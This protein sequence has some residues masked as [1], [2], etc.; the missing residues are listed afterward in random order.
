MPVV[1]VV[2]LA[3]PGGTTPTIDNLGIIVTSYGSMGYDEYAE[4]PS[5][6]IVLV[7]C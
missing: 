6:P 7:D 2:L 1:G 5:M 3:G 4:W